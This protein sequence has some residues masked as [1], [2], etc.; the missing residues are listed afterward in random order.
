MNE[1]KKV[2]VL[3]LCLGLYVILHAMVL[4]TIER[5]ELKMMGEI[6]NS[7]LWVFYGVWLPIVGGIIIY[8]ICYII[9]KHIKRKRGE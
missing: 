6:D 4:P 7:W 8:I 1:S 2:D 5:V 3:T 9:D